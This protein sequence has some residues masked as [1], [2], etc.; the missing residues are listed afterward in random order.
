MQVD[1]QEGSMYAYSKRYRT[2][3]GFWKIKQRIWYGYVPTREYKI[4]LGYK[5][6][7][8]LPEKDSCI[9]EILP[10]EDESNDWEKE[11]IASH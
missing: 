11:L 7:V 5:I 6:L 2:M 10:T 4:Y 9:D 8:V 1:L 3:V